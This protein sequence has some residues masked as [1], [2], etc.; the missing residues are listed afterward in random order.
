[1][2]WVAL[3]MFLSLNVP[4]RAVELVGN[5][6]FESG[7]AGWNVNHPWY[8]EGGPGQGNGLSA[9]EWAP[10]EGR[11]G[12]AALRL[13]GAANRGLA[14]QVR[15]AYPQVPL[16]IRAWIRTAGLGL[17]QASVL[18]EFKAADGRYLGGQSPGGVGGDSDWTLLEGTVQA[19]P[20]AHLMLIDL[21]TNTANNGQAWFD[22]LSLTAEPDSEPPPPV[23]PQPGLSGEATR[24]NVGWETSP[25]PDVVRYLIFVAE[26][27]WEKLEGL[28]PVRIAPR[29]ATEVALPD[30]APNRPLYVAVVAEDLSGN[31]SAP[32]VVALTPADR[33]PPHPV[34]PRITRR[35]DGALRATW[36][37]DRRDGDVAGY[38]L[39]LSPAPGEPPR[40][41]WDLDAAAR[42]VMVTEGVNAGAIRLIAFDAAG[43]E[44]ASPWVEVPPPEA[45]PTPGAAQP[46][47]DLWITHALHNVFRDT[48]APPAAETALH[49]VAVRGEAEAAQIV[50]RARQEGIGPVRLEISPLIQDSGERLPADAVRADFVGY[51]HLTRNSRATPPEEVARVVPADFPD[52]LLEEAELELPAGANQPVL[53]QVTVPR[54][55]APGLYRGEV[56]VC[57]RQGTLAV[58][59]T[60]EVL[61]LTL[62]EVLPLQVTFWF[63]VGAIARHHGVEEW[64]EEHWNLLRAYG[65]DMR[66][67]GQTMFEVGLDL[68]QVWR[69]ADGS[70]TFDY[71]DFDRWV[72]LF[73]GLGFQR[74]ELM[75]VGGREHGQWEDRT[76]IAYPRPAIDRETGQGTE[77]PLETFLANL[78]RHLEER[79]WLERTVLHIADE[80]I[81][82]N[83]ESWRAL[84]RRVHAAAPRLKRIDAIHVTE[85]DGDL[86]VWVPQLNYFA[87]A[88]ES[89]RAKQQAGVMELWYY[90]AWVPQGQFPNRLLDYPLLKT[91]L[92]PWVAARY[93]ASG[94]LHWGLNFWNEEVDPDQSAFSPGDDF[95][96]YPGTDGPRSSLRWEAF[97]DGVEDHALLMLWRERDPEAA[98][99]ALN[100]VVPSFTGY[101]RDP[102]VMLSIRQ[103]ALAALVR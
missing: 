64:S 42:E 37:A 17:A 5:G 103:Q 28:K 18:I 27:P 44:A 74:L 30:C 23:T 38:R 48:P 41:T 88:Y 78:Q 29:K 8:E 76:F 12:S 59:L 102:A 85:L 2:R 22:D 13:T 19:P 95:I 75:H 62:P 100:E 32:V 55:A 47:I 81:P 14:M 43:N 73:L 39:E 91:R 11:N 35:A 83:V 87:D 46:P 7:L 20:E 40:R 49:L 21:L 53:V 24:L 86:E 36:R 54:Q 79:G 77:V 60:V 50:L 51:V 84:S 31:R 34:V 97:R 96:V 93:G 92:L 101:P 80:P 71:S 26:Q 90:T 58:P 65:A 57:T 45:T 9:V 94:F 72:R 52:P 16:R 1:M 56:Y 15:E 61:P 66:A 68:V 89:L 4:C 3:G 33:C 70:Y 99:A 82:V 25:A 67:H 69:E 10:G 63:N 6:G 98:A